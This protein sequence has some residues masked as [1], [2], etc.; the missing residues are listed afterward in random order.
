MPYEHILDDKE[1]RELLRIAR[2]TLRERFRSGRVPP[3]APH[4]A[5]LTDPAAAF[6]SLHRGEE[7]RGCIGTLEEQTPLYKT[8]QEM[9]IGAATR[10]PRFPPV[11]ADELDGLT[12][13]ISVLSHRTPVPATEVTARLRIGD[14]G[15]YVTAPGA[16]GVLLPQ[17][18]TEHGWDP[19][20]FLRQTCRKAGL[21]EEA[22]RDDDTR[23][24]LFQAQV[25]DEKL[26]ATS[27]VRVAIVR[28]TVL[29]RVGGRCDRR[30]EQGR[31]ARERERGVARAS[32]RA[33]IAA[34]LERSFCR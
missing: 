30:A 8:V 7:L 12:I 29:R 26:L 27:P 2:A 4:R 16:R 34:P 32:T 17:V 13:E 18:A 24:E 20:E 14:H 25:F 23:I 1:K 9:A 22:W 11:D 28:R 19:Q 10:D 15:L 31:A 5:S 3:G 6:V 33:S 21:S